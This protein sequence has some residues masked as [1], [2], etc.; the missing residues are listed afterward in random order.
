MAMTRREF[1]GLASRMAGALA[2]GTACHAVSPQA[3]DGRLS[4]KPRRG[5]ATAAAG[6]SRLGLA[7]GRDATLQMP[8]QADA[9]PLP[10]LVLLHGAGGSGD[11]ILRRLGS[12]A[13]A[14]GIV[15]LSPDARGSSWDAIR[16]HFGADVEFIDRCLDRV[17]AQVNVDPRR[18]SIGGFSDGAT[19][20][21]SL[22]LVNGELFQRIVAWSPGFVVGGTVTGKPKIY[23]SHGHEDEILTIDRCS[24][25]I[26][27][28]L[29]RNGYEVTYKE[30][31]GGHTI[32]EAIAREG[33][34]FAAS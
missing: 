18:I 34:A 20:A 3:R 11:G 7:S 33:M 32:P 17:F 25:R 9:G 15:V 16:D 10:L 29:K 23:V 22:G 24:R 19:Y 12:F 27:P 28:A 5:A 31:V 4:A 1:A 30:F 8:P 26:V 13:A 6:T 14:A 21:L 2:L